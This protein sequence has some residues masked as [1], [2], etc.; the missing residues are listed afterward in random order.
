M[1]APRMYRVNDDPWS[2]PVIIHRTI[3]ELPRNYA[4]RSVRTS[5]RSTR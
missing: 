3:S 1:S 2:I 4:N 5:L